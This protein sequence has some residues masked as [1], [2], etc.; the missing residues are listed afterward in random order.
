VID[1]VWQ[2]LPASIGRLTMLT[3]LNVDRNQLSDIPREVTSHAPVDFN[4]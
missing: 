1:G 2:E 3:I 4:V